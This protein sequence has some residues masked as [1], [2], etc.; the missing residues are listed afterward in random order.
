MGKM[1]EKK[2]LILTCVIVFVLV[3]GTGFALYF[4][5]SEREPIILKIEKTNV[6]IEEAKNIAPTGVKEPP[7]PCK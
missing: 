5:K 1:S 6:L 3:S 7:G 4:L 2:L